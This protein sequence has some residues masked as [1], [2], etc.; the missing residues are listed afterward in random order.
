MNIDNLTDRSKGFLQAAQTIALREGH[1]QVL[2]LHLLKALLDDKEGQCTRLIATSSGDAHKAVAEVMAALSKVPKVEGSNAQMYFSQDL[3]RL[4]DRAAQLS[5]KAGDSF[6][7]VEYLLLALA[8]DKATDA[9]QS[10][11]K[12]GVS[13]DALNAA[14]NNHDLKTVESF[15]HPDFIGKGPGGHT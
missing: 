14:I 9:G 11:D 13:P 2:P 3:A 12:A 8:M 15:L 1:Q 4:L 7:T 5:E 6:V 10:L